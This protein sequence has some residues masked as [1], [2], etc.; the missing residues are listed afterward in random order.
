MAKIQQYDP[1]HDL[2]QQDE[3]MLLAQTKVNKYKTAD[4]T[5]YY[6]AGFVVVGLVFISAF[7]IK[8]NEKR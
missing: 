4:I 7:I 1:T 8:N 6:I 3:L 5:T 2:E